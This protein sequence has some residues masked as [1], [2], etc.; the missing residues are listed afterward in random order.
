MNFER[1]TLDPE[2]LD[3]A[4]HLDGLQGHT[5]GRQDEYGHEQ[6]LAG[7]PLQEVAQLAQLVLQPRPN[8][9]R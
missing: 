8:P 3:P 1:L 2:L 7:V 6:H 5:E 9:H 4:V